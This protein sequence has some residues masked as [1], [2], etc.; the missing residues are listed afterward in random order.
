MCHSQRDGMS[1][2]QKKIKKKNHFNDYLGRISSFSPMRCKFI[3]FAN[4]NKI[5]S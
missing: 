5:H 4:W 3:S 2:I 1:I